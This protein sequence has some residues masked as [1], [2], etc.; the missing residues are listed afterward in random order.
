MRE[1][2]VA[3]DGFTYERSAIEAWRQASEARAAAAGLD[4]A[5][6]PVRS[7]LT[8]EPLAHATLTPNRFV[9]S[10][11]QDMLAAQGRR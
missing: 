5:T 7:P 4:P 3:A 1:P 10:A 9:R 11:I 8:N 6:A 2:V